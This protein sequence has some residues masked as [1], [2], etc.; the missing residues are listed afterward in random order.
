MNSDQIEGK[1]KKIKGQFKQKYGK[2][3]DDDVTYSEGK[4]D[5]MLGNL[6]EKTGRSKEQL[7]DE[8]DKM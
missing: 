1:W 4:F 3:T 6:Q 8:I 5:E 2:L 7:K